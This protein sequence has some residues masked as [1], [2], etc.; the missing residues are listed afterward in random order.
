MDGG[1]RFPWDGRQVAEGGA[2]RIVSTR[3]KSQ[4]RPRLGVARLSRATLV[5]GTH[6]VRKAAPQLRTCRP[7]RH[8]SCHFGGALSP[9]SPLYCASRLT[10][11]SYALGRIPASWG[12]RIDERASTPGGHC[13]DAARPS[14][15]THVKG[16]TYVTI[17]CRSPSIWDGG[18][19]ES[20]PTTKRSA[21]PTGRAPRQPLGTVLFVGGTAT[22][23]STV[24]V[25][26]RG[27]DFG[28]TGRQLHHSRLICSAR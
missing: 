8:G 20:A 12:D 2:R 6:Q 26:G 15:H 5:R 27:G 19:R 24:Q 11:Q 13:A 3:A 17:H 16:N 1:G 28:S 21:P 4:P 23:P 18:S 25:G 10:S 9:L 14:I 7:E 22:Y